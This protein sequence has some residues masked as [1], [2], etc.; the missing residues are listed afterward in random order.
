[1]KT[2]PETLFVEEVKEVKQIS[3]QLFL[4]FNLDPQFWHARCGCG[5]TEERACQHW[6]VKIAL[7]SESAQKYIQQRVAAP[8][9]SSVKSN[10][11]L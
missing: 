1:V 6:R 4:S 3:Q 7:L 11:V 9:K 8:I 5:Q 2:N 10:E